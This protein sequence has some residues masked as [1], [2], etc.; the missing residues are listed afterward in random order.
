M[1]Y[2]TVLGLLFTICIILLGRVLRLEDDL[3]EKNKIIQMFVN[4]RTDLVKEADENE[5]W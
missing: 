4:N 1:I 2:L 5:L 3:A